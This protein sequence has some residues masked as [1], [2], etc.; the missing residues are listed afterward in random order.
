MT[1]LNDRPAKL[2]IRISKKTQRDV[3]L[4]K[5]GKGIYKSNIC[6][7]SVVN[8]FMASGLVYIEKKG[9]MSIVRITSKGK[10]LCKDLFDLRFKYGEGII[11]S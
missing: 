11:N 2:L 3:P 9:N 5:L 10:D 7:A 6:T 8:E 1:F 4:T